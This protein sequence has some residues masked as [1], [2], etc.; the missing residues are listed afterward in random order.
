MLITRLRPRL[1]LPAIEFVWGC[2]VI[3]YIG[4]SNKAG[5]IALRFILGMIEAGFFVSSKRSLSL[6]NSQER[7]CI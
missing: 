6:M 1:Y 4:V 7:C 2:V 5:L 3:A